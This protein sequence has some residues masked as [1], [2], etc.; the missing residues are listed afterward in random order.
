M[1][2]DYIN[3]KYLHLAMEV[4]NTNDKWKILLKFKLAFKVFY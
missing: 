3:E 4:N 1:E 2:T